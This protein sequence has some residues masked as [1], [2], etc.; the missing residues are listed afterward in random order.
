MHQTSCTNTTVDF[1]IEQIVATELQKLFKIL[2]LAG[3]YWNIVV[4]YHGSVHITQAA[5]IVSQRVQPSLL[6]I[7]C[8][9]P[10]PV[11][12]QLCQLAEQCL[13]HCLAMSWK[14]DYQ[15]MFKGKGIGKIGR[16]KQNAASITGCRFEFNPAYR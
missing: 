16:E 14:G 2:L 3:V 1:P 13:D 6:Q 5:V 4:C 11:N 12:A 9:R 10:L 15:F 8:S 7:V